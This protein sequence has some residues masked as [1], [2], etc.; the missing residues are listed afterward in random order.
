MTNERMRELLEIYGADPARWPPGERG[1][2]AQLDADAK[3]DA[4]RLDALMN[5]YVRIPLPKL[6]M[7]TLVARI[8]ATPQP[9]G[10]AEVAVADINMAGWRVSFGWRRLAGLASVA[11]IGFVVGLTDIDGSL[12]Q[13]DDEELNPGIVGVLEDPSW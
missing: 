10:F 7:N 8:T 3:R 2:A 6:D 1:A 9:R 4:Q 5:R 12:A 11:L 13:V